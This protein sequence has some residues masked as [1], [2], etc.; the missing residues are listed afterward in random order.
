M[1]E[2]M[3]TMA[4][5]PTAMQMKK[6][7]SRLQEARVSRTAIRRMNIRPPCRRAA[8]CAVS[9]SRRRVPASC[10]TRISVVLRVCVDRPQHFHDVTPV[11]RVEIPGWLVGQHDR[12]IVGQRAR[13][14]DALLLAAGQLR[15][16]VMRAV[17]QAHLFEQRPRAGARIR[18]VP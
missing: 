14:R 11:G 1:T 17:G 2:R 9:A 8:K 5:T 13:Q 15:R 18:G 6:N 7:S 10:V 16:I 12:R 3:A 4:A